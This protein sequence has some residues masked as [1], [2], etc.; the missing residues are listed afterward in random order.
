MRSRT[1]G[2]RFVR[3]KALSSSRVASS[4]VMRIMHNYMGTASRRLEASQEVIGQARNAP[5]MSDAD[6]L[7][8]R[9]AYDHAVHF[10]E[11][12]K[13]RSGTNQECGVTPREEIPEK[14]AGRMRPGT[15]PE[16]IRMAVNDAIVGRRPRS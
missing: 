2:E 14:V 5:P 13:F 10:L 7:V 1:L 9:A 4:I 11:A 8:Y 16:L 6:W 15:D 12:I 3:R